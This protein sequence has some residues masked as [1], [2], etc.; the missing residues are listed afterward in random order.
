MPVPSARE[1]RSASTSSDRTQPWGL[2]PLC[3]SHRLRSYASRT[4]RSWAYFIA[5]LD[6]VNAAGERAPGFPWRLQ[7]EDGNATSIR[8]FEWDA[9]DSHRVIVNLTTWA[10]VEDLAAFVFGP[11]H[12]PIM[13]RRSAGSGSRRS[14][15]R[16]PR[17]RVPPVIDKRRVRQRTG[18]ATYVC[19]ADL[20]RVHA[21]AVVDRAERYEGYRCAER[22]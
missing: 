9:G 19:T 11:A 20:V 4:R 5:A 2:P 10:S 21:A 17:W 22:Q 1:R 12:A 14:P 13:R 8:V 6:E 3:S 7:T 16:P 18:C 15:S